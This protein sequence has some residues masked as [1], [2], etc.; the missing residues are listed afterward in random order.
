MKCATCGMPLSPNRSQANC[1]KCGAPASARAS[2]KATIGA[3]GDRQYAPSAFNASPQS[4]V[5]P[6]PIPGQGWRSGMHERTDFAPGLQ[7]PRPPEFQ[8]RSQPQPPGNNRNNRLGFTIAGLCLLAGAFLLILVYILAIGGQGNQAT[9][10]SQTTPKSQTIPSPTTVP[11]PTA[12]PFPGQQYINNA[13]LS[14]SQPPTLQTTNTFTAN[15]KIYVTFMHPSRQSGVV[16]LAWYLNGKE[17]NSYTIAMGAN[18]TSSYGYEIFGSPGSG[19]VNLYW[20]T[21][22]TCSNELLAQ[23]IIFTVT[24]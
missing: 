8:R 18:T 4:P 16:C 20:A 5:S 24:T 15:Q 3:I 10:I 14:S 2:Q 19:Y 23:Q 21:D 6:Q 12:T 22:T 7:Q 11:S 1:P 17:S 13:Q 9:T